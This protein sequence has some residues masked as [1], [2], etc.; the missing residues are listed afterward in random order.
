MLWWCFCRSLNWVAIWNS[1]KCCWPVNVDQ[2]LSWILLTVENA[3]NMMLC[4]SGWQ[5]QWLCCRPDC[6]QTDWSGEKEEQG[7]S[8]CQTFPGT[9]WCLLKPQRLW[10]CNFVV[11]CKVLVGLCV[12]VKNHMWLFVNCL[13]ENPSFDSQTKENMTL[14]Q[15]NFG[16]TCSL[17]EK[18]VKQVRN[19]TLKPSWIARTM[20]Y[21]LVLNAPLSNIWWIAGAMI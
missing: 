13:I 21:N 1:I 17:S 15:K 6:V 10:Q 3:L 20:L 2:H 14:Q 16:S 4:V 12:Q 18:F 9:S 11:R 7:W 5:T 8:G 19:V